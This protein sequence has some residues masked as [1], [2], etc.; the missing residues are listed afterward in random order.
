MPKIIIKPVIHN[1]NLSFIVG[2]LPYNAKAAV[3]CLSPSKHPKR[4]K[5]LLQ[6]SSSLNSGVFTCWYIKSNTYSCSLSD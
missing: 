5:A 4:T 1:M 2:P 6:T 3:Y